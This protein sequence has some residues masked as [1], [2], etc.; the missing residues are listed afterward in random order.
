[1]KEDDIML[2]KKIDRRD[3]F[4]T[5]AKAGAALAFPLFVPA[6]VL[7][8]GGAVAPSERI[9]LGAIGIGPRGRLVLGCMLPE[10]DV[11]FVAICDVQASRR[12]FVKNMADEHYG[13]KDCVMYRDLRELLARPDIDAV[14]I[15]TGDRWHT[16]AS[17]MA[18]KAGKDVYSEKPCGITIADCQALD[19]TMRRL[20]RVF[21]AGTQRRNIANFQYAVQLARSGKLGQLRTLHA[22]A[23]VPQVDHTWLPAEPVPDRELVD[24]DMWLGPCP[25]R[26]YNP[27]YVAGRWRKYYDFDSGATLLDW[28]AHTIDLCQ[29]ANDADS[30]TPLEFVPSEKNITATYANGVK[31]VLDF[32]P[33]AFGDRAPHYRTELGTCPVRFEGDEGWVETGDA[34]DMVVQ[35]AKL[36][37][38]RG[39]AREAGIRPVGHTRNFFDCIRS[40][41]KPAANSAIMRKSHLACHAAAIA[42]E[43]GR[44]LKFDP[45][46]EE[47]IGDEAA[48]RLRSRALRAPWHV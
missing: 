38:T 30:T 29:M 39:V 17:I 13:T 4:K 18:A 8:R 31:L 24:W 12:E 1:V 7:G 27:A 33:D 43:L 45:V 37:D 41:A 26:P 14:L 42:W 23:Y 48:N 11:Q 34:G 15:A 20:G 46:K 25:W 16:M 5:T 9:T 6:S 19:D 47:F 2:K 28:G 32:L 10:P 36:C 22:S 21:Q 44:T 3:F 35:P 40:R